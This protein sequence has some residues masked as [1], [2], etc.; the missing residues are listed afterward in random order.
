MEW[1]ILNILFVVF[2]GSLV[3]SR[4]VR[5]Y[6][7]GNGVIHHDHCFAKARSEPERNKDLN[8]V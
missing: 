4:P 1:I 5:M 3:A 8:I 7:K 6:S 2:G